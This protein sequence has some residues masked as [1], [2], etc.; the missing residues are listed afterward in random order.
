MKNKWNV[1]YYVFSVVAY[2]TFLLVGLGAVTAALLIL[3]LAASNLL[4]YLDG[5]DRASR[6]IKAVN[7]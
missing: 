5:M 6:I 1:W 4:G 2:V 7:K 3:T